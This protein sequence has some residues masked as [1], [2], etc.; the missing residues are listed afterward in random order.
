M[1]KSVKVV[2][3]KTVDS[4][5][6]HN[7]YEIFFMFLQLKHPDKVDGLVLINCTAKQAGWVEWGYQKVCL[8]VCA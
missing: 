4:F 8:C 6:R 3:G 1:H 7:M 2:Y 5:S